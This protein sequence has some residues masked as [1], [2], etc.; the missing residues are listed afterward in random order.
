MIYRK[1]TCNGITICVA[2]IS[3]REKDKIENLWSN[4]VACAVFSQTGDRNKIIRNIVQLT[5]PLPWQIQ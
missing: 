5:F 3:E 4:N 2:I 1:C